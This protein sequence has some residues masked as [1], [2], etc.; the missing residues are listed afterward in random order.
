[1]CVCCSRPAARF[2]VLGASLFKWMSQSPLGMADRVRTR[3]RDTRDEKT[4]R[5]RARQRETGWSG[6]VRDSH[7]A[8]AA[9]P[10]NCRMGSD[11]VE[12]EWLWQGRLT[13]SS[14]RPTCMRPAGRSPSWLEVS[15]VVSCFAWSRR[16]IVGATAMGRQLFEGETFSGHP[17]ELPIPSR[18]IDMV[19]PYPTVVRGCSDQASPI[20]MPGSLYVVHI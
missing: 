9:L 12:W 15:V 6:T 20:L 17:R 10:S 14:K 7:S 8:L 4:V 16:S 18:P 2:L 5:E 3:S 1:M 11:R 13:S 19:E